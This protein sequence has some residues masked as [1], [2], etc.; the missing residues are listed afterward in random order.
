MSRDE[1]IHF[2]DP[3]GEIH[4]SK[5]EEVTKSKI[6]TCFKRGQNADRNTFTNGGY[7]RNTIE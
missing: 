5:L 4:L 6:S 3:Q 7:G 1:V 2:I